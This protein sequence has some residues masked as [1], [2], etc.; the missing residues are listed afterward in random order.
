MLSKHVSSLIFHPKVL[1]IA[2]CCMGVPGYLY[3]EQV[4]ELH[5][6]GHAF[7]H[8]FDRLQMRHVCIAVHHKAT[9]F[10]RQRI[11]MAP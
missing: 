3:N 9:S 6:D 10:L 8:T 5:S 4:D 2:E 11:P 7:L 1:G